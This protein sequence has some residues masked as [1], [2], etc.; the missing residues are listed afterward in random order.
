MSFVQ[1]YGSQEYRDYILNNSATLIY[2]DPRFIELIADHLDARSSWLVARQEKQII[3][4]MP[5]LV[6]DGPLGPVFNSLPYYGCNG[7]VIQVGKDINS[8]IAL[9]DSFY[10]IAYE[11]KAV[12]ATIINNPLED[13]AAFYKHH[14]KA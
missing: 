11:S 3:G 7:G 4:L 2:S 6:K 5:F 8:K 10:A 13:D 14:A 1:A 12:S 9:I